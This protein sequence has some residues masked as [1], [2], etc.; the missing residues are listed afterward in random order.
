[1]RRITIPAYAKVNLRLHALG[2]RADSYHEL[3]TIFQAISLHDTLEMELMR[4]GGIQL[5]IE[6]SRF[7]IQDSKSKKDAEVQSSQRRAEELPVGRE[8]L[9]WR[10]VEAFRRGFKIKSGVRV[11]LTKRI[12]IGAGLGGGSS[13]AAAALMGMMRLTGNSKFQIR[14]SKVKNQERRSGAEE[15]G[16]EYPPFQ[17]AK[18]WGTLVEIAASLGA[19]VPFFLLGGRA[20]GVGRGDE[21]YPLPD[22]P[23]AQTL[24]VVAPSGMAINTREAYGW[25]SAHLTKRR[26]SP[27]ISSFC[28]LCWSPQEAPLENDFEAVV[29]RRHPRLA[30]IKRELLRRGALDAALAGSGS[31]VFGVYRHPAQARRTAQSF[32]NARTFVVET[33]SREKYRKALSLS[34]RGF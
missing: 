10:A 29:F 7:K 20:L 28:A 22:L 21:V 18:G 13:D 16:G 26:A 8:N 15:R 19:D 3:R 11:R 23:R 1:M 24:L 34:D 4:G 25:L 33:L 6:N 5:E 32:P 14:D 30:G 31:A 2:R 9:V 12:P 27:K 17:T